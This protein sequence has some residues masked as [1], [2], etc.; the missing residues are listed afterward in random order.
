[1]R[2][3]A[4]HPTPPAAPQSITPEEFAERFERPRLPVV[5]TGLTGGWAANAAWAPEALLRAYGGHKF[6]ARRARRGGRRAERCGRL[7]VRACGRGAGPEAAG[8]PPVFESV[9]NE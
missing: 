4:A 9:P 6:K 7:A 3:A 8:T 1:L 2:P 5:V